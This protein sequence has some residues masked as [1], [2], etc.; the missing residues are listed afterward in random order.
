MNAPSAKGLFQ[1]AI[2]ESGSYITSFNEKSASQRVA[3]AVLEELHLQPAQVDSLQKIPYD[4][5]NE[6]GKKATRKV[7]AEMRKEGKTG[8]A[9]WNAVLDGEFFPNQPGDP[10]AKELSKNVPLMVGTAKNEFTAFAMAGA[11]EKTMD[12]VKA[13]LQ[14]KYGDKTDAYLAAVKAAYPNTEKPSGYVDIDL[15]FR[16]LAIK[17]ADAKAVS[18]AAPVYMYLF[19]WQSPVNGGI[20]RAMHCMDIAFQFNNIN[21]C[22][23]MTGGGKEAIALA[24]KVSGAWINFA[25]NRQSERAGLTKM[26]GLHP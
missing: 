23:E 7:A 10:A 5:L 12:E 26:A 22:Q 21:R 14:K 16:P 24:D 17:Q 2:V 11:K 3:A 6:A 25:R 4:V 9:G 18:G 19:T 20:Y 15:N 1:K 13:D 8:G